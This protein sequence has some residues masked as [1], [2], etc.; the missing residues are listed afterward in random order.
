MP[1]FDYEG[2]RLYYVDVARCGEDCGVPVMFVHGAGSSHAIWT[3]QIE[4]F[5]RERRVI[6]PDLS[7][8]GNS[9][10]P[11]E[12]EVDISENCARELEAL[13]EHLMLNDFVLVGHSMGGGVAMAYVLNRPARMPHAMALVDTSADL[14]LSRLAPGLLIETVETYFGLIR[15]MLTGSESLAFKI[16]R[17]EEEAKRA[18][19]EMV[20]RDLRACDRFSIQDRLPEIDIPVFVIHG[21]DD[22]IIPRVVAEQLTKALPRADIALVRDSDH[23]PMVQQPREFNRLL[24]EFLHWVDRGVEVRPQ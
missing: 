8:H 10:L 20:Q 15:G 2:L 17:E 11:P 16:L 22:D 9:D 19:P 4:E 21:T 7:G 12:E 13:I 1:F 6:A 3:L 24:R 18:H 23:C 14:D 5:S